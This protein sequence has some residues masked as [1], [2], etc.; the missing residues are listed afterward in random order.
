MPAVADSGSFRSAQIV[1]TLSVFGSRG[2]GRSSLAN[3]RTTVPAAS[4]IS[5]VTAPDG[6]AFR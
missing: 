1:W 3:R 5:S 4:T 6:A 2:C